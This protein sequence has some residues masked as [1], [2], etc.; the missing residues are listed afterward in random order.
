MAQLSDS[1][2]ISAFQSAFGAT[3]G[4]D[5]PSPG[6]PAG[7]GDLVQFA[8]A[9]ADR[10]GVPPG[11]AQ[12]L[13][14]TESGGRADAVSPKGAFGP[15]QLMPATARELAQKYGGD[16]SNPYDNI[17]LG[18]RYLRDNYDRFGDWRL[19][20]AA[21]HAGPGAVQRAGGIPGGGDGIMRTADYVRAI[22]GDARPAT[23]DPSVEFSLTPR[24]PVPTPVAAPA[25]IVPSPDGADFGPPAPTLADIRLDPE[26]LPQEFRGLASEQPR[27]DIDH[28]RDAGGAVKA[29][30]FGANFKEGFKR[31]FV[32]SKGLAGGAAALLGDQFDNP[33][34]RQWGMDLYA[35][36]MAEAQ[37]YSDNASFSDFLDGKVQATDWMA[38]TL[39]YLGYQAAESVL[40]GGVGAVLGKAVG[41]GFVAATLKPLVAREAG[42][43]AATEAGAKMTA[44][45]I[46]K[47]ALAHTA[48]I[49]GAGAAIFANNLRQEAGSI[50]PDAVEQGDPNLAHVWLGSLGAAA[51]DTAAE[52]YVGKNLLG[53]GQPRAGGYLSRLGKEAGSQMLV[54]GGTEGAQGVIEDV[55]AHKDPF[56]PQGLR[57]RIDEIAV[58]A[59]G[60]AAGTLSRGRSRSRSPGDGA[61][62][63]LVL[64]AA[65]E[66]ERS[67]SGSRSRSR[68]RSRGRSPPK[69]PVLPPAAEGAG[70]GGEGDEGF[71]QVKKPRRGSPGTNRSRSN[72]PPP[73]PNN[74]FALLG[75]AAAA[76]EVAAASGEADAEAMTDD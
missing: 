63:Q 25:A 50:Y 28:T 10:L 39:G 34:L 3:Q 54:Q 14:R 6:R 36:S 66:Q 19:A 65:A 69:G 64:A 40:A 52:A 27:L 21:Y 33:A 7:G 74:R 37:Q 49:A 70:A 67:G 1:D 12:R 62:G 45:Q 11:I 75:A 20:T 23:G 22:A 51:L 68:S 35:K 73:S 38:D 31:G 71:Q 17:S 5:A 76:A 26:Q 24:R 18:M 58:G 43:I 55:S 56:S 16:P 59:L 8:A 15:A 4:G 13:V 72:S 2:L 41:K 53:M 48:Q 57:Q 9:E 60:G 44:E 47:L 46:G 42:R 29:S 61:A 30:G 32:Q